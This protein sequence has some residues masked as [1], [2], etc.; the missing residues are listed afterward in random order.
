MKF[1]VLSA[2]ISESGKEELKKL[3][4]TAVAQ[5][6]YIVEVIGYADASGHAAMNEKLSETRAKAVVAYLI[7]QF[8]ASGC[9]GSDGRISAGGS[10]R[11]QGRTR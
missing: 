1:A 6:G 3:G 11:D 10:E 4:E 9:S 7:Q 5:K 2:K 8:A